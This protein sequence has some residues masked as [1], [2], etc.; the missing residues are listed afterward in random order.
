MANSKGINA[1][2]NVS[3]AAQFP[4]RPGYGTAGRP[5]V[6][7]ANYFKIQVPAG[8]AVTRYSVEVTPEAKG[9]KLARIFQLL[10]EMPEF[11]GLVSDMSSM[12]I[13]AKPLGIPDGHT[14]Q[15]PYMAEG[16]DEP[17][18]NAIVYT[19][20]VITP[21]PIMISDLHNHLCATDPSPDLALKAEIIQ[22]LNVIFGHHAQS[23]DG[24][25]TTGKNRHFSIDRQQS[26][27]HNIT[28]L[29][30]GLESLRGFYLSVR[31]AT[32]G[33]ILNVNSSHNVF[34]QPDR[35]DRL[36]PLLGTGNKVILQKKLKLMRVRVIHLP[37][38][39]AKLTQRE[40]PRVKTIFGLAHPNDGQKDPHPPRVAGSG[41]GPNDV[42]F[43]LSEPPPPK[44]GKTSKAGKKGGQSLPSN[45]Y[46]SVFDYFK[47]SKWSLR[48][49]IATRTNLF[50]NTPIS[51]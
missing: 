8:L 13:A 44:N 42:K 47:I 7:Y 2:A 16:Q 30:G 33:L 19:A 36:F 46:I 1:L 12:I 10:L 51:R 29:G 14:V 39:V 20:R 35:L 40:I 41:A 45:Q 23:H 34:L 26:N 38:K 5:I 11:S 50:Q 48:C 43:W 3:L 18:E 27:S 9:K 37:A 21:L 25:V 6:V 4:N 31:P 28:V 24:V 15:I 49:T 17:L 22:V 32:G